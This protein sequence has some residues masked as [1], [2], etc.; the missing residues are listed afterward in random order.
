[1]WK[2]FLSFDGVDH[3]SEEERKAKFSCNLYEAA[4]K[5]DLYKVAEALAHKG[6][7]EWV[8]TEDGGKTPLHMCAL[9]KRREGK[10][11]GTL[12]KLRSFFIENEPKWTP[13]IQRRTTFWTVHS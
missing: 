7:V 8:N 12:L 1:M 3:M 10:K 13:W 4:K 9:A 6:S 11:N 2:G 5:N